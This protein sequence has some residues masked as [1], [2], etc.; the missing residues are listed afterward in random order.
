MLQ[1]EKGLRVLREIL[2]EIQ[3]RKLEVGGGKS[4]SEAVN[5]LKG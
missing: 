3:R 1:F 4:I 2:R 5:G